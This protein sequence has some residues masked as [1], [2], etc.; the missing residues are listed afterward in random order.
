MIANVT[1]SV[2]SKKYTI[3]DTL[4][5]ELPSS[6]QAG[7]FVIA[8]QNGAYNV[9]GEDGRTVPVQVDYMMN[10]YSVQAGMVDNAYYFVMPAE[11]VTI[12]S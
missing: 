2:A 9:T 10:P 12:T 4:G 5:R 6:A 7:E 8:K 11:N 1:P 3:T